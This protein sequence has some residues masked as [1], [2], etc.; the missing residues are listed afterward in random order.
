MVIM[1]LE[2][3]NVYKPQYPSQ[4]EMAVRTRVGGK[5]ELSKIGLQ[6]RLMRLVVERTQS[7]GSLPQLA[8][9]VEVIG[10][11]IAME[12]SPARTSQTPRI[13]RQ[14]QVGWKLSAVD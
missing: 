3:G 6:S 7:P 10:L 8:H 14:D 2:T 1:Y 11:Q 12:S 5:H 4:T 13:H 9:R